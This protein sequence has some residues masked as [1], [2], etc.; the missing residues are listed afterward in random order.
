LP[1]L[2]SAL[3]S[4]SAAIGRAVTVSY[5][6]LV[7]MVR[8]ARDLI[9]RTGL[10]RGWGAVSSFLIPT[11]RSNVLASYRQDEDPLPVNRHPLS[12]RAAEAPLVSASLSPW[13]SNLRRRE[14]LSAKFKLTPLTLVEKRKRTFLEVRG[15]WEFSKNGK[16][17]TYYQRYVLCM[18]HALIV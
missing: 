12:Y 15:E 18:C 13:T 8:P 5:N 6:V 16:K 11:A 2:M 10:R 14:L 7:R 1:A 9:D 4:R 17:Y 3:S